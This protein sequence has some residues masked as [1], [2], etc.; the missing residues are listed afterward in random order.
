M[1]IQNFEDLEIWK[2]ARRLTE[3]VYQLRG[4]QDS[5]RTLPSRI[6]F[7][8]LQFP[9]CR[10]FQRVSSAG[11]IKNSFNFSMWPKD[12]A[13]KCVLSFTWRLIKNMSIRR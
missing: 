7:G 2:E 8:A 10:I 9:S 1:A 13:G 11:E 6:R 3:A 5:Q 12:L 4:I